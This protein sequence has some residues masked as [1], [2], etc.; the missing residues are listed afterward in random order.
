MTKFNVEKPMMTP[1]L[2][3]KVNTYIIVNSKRHSEL[4]V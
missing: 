2:S 1:L 3:I 4:K